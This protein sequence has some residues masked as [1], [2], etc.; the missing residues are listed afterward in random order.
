M[1]RAF[2]GKEMG[3]SGG[4]G[5]GGM[6][7]RAIGRRIVGVNNSGVQDKSNNN[8]NNNI[9]SLSTRCNPSS[10]LSSPCIPV[11]ATTSNTVPLPTWSSNS[12]YYDSDV[13]DWE[14]VDAYGEQDDEVHGTFDKYIF[15]PVPSREEVEDAVSSLQ[16]FLGAPSYSQLTE[17]G[18][19]SGSEKESSYHTPSPSSSVRR[20]PSYG[21]ELDWL[22]PSLLY[23]NSRMQQLQGYE[24]ARVHEA[25]S[26]LQNE[27]SVQRVVVSLSTDRAVWDAVLN[28]NVVREL[29]D[30][31]AAENKTAPRPD[32]NPAAAKNIL[33]WILDNSKAKLIE[34]MDKVTKLLTVFQPSQMEEDTPRTTDEFQE[35]LKSSLLVSIVV[36][37]IVVMTRAHRV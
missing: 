9:L 3:G 17:D 34:L 13:W 6:I 14:H 16:H 2:G 11:S 35:R 4:G 7:R 10:S 19:N 22:E 32:G 8:S 37:L 15:G 21:S 31:Y 20:V 30:T 5:G 24:R 27:P 1:K 12:L 18:L 25:F 29:R 33:S 26:L 36:L 28:N 23:S